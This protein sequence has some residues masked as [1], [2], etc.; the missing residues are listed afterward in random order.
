M[1]LD[2]LYKKIV[3]L[4]AFSASKVIADIINENGDY[5]SSLLRSQ[6]EKGK[7]GLGQD[8]TLKRNGGVFPYYSD[9]TIFEKTRKGQNTEWITYKDSGA[10]YTSIYVYASGTSFIFDSDVPY[11]SDII[12]KSGSGEETMYLDKENLSIFRNEILIP[13]FKIAFQLKV[14]NV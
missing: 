9:R 13:Q 11:F 6:L 10:F 7:D 3:A 5:I 1:G 14:T 12:L 4:E 2:N 8:L